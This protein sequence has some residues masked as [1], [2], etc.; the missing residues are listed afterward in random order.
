MTVHRAVVGL[1]AGIGGFEVG[2]SQAGH[3]ATMLVENA[4][5][6]AHV[7]RSRFPDV[8]LEGDIN[9]LR[10]L[11]PDTDLVVAGFPCQDLS[12]VG[13]KQGIEASKSSLVGEVFRLL[14]TA[15]VPWIV[16]ENVPFL[17][18]LDRGRAL[19]LV[20]SELQR[21]GYAWAYRIVDTSAF[22]LPQRRNRWFMVASKAGD[23]RS[24][25]LADDV[26][27]DAG[28]Q[29]PGRTG[30]EACGFYW[31]E[32]KRAL[33]WAVDG[34]P[35]IKCGSSVGVASPPAIWLPDGRFVTPDI[36]DAERLQGFAVDW[37]EPAATVARSGQRWRLVGNAVSVPV[38]K[39]LGERLAVPGSYAASGD[40]ERQPDEPW[41]R[42]AAWS[43]VDGPVHVADVG[44]W[45]VWLARPPLLEFL[46]Y[47][48]KLL[49]T[50]AASGFLRRA[51][52]ASLRFPP[53][54]LEDLRRHVEISS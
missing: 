48:G 45:P 54:L 16:L 41:P 39:W 7:L 38:A 47:E 4:L 15:D 42:R 50:R 10:S 29:A 44:P 40:R 32:G 14:E 36:R 12:S 28:Q 23:P 18:H 35:P 25:L 13:R 30:K 1:F 22:G 3:R 33:G 51:E 8:K 5:P 17:L 20:T 9:L 31:T 37:T 46:R 34:V 11:P 24:V 52:H 2:L 53:G 49:S 43:G 21:L 26:T 6:A 19:S 27:V